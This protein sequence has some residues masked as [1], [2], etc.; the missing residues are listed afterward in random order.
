L[1]VGTGDFLSPGRPYKIRET[2]SPHG[3]AMEILSPEVKK[4]GT[5]SGHSHLS[6][7]KI[8]NA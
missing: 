5:E 6:G 2:H 1:P 3:M 7:V 8:K 4:T